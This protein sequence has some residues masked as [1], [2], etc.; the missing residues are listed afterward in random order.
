MASSSRLSSRPSDIDGLRILSLGQQGFQSLRPGS[1]V[2]NCTASVI[3]LALD[4]LECKASILALKRIT[5]RIVDAN[6][7]IPELRSLRDSDMDSK[8][9]LYLSSIR[10][11]FPHVLVTNRVGMATKNGRTNKQDCSGIFEPK[12]AAVIE[13]NETVRSSLDVHGKEDA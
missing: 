6:Q 1:T 10:R 11:S 13:I 9:N 7:A 2:F 3:S 4:M 8:V 12:T 5:R